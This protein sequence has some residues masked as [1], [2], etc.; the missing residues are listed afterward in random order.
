MAQKEK[1]K[2]KE[3]GG[4]R[5]SRSNAF[6]PQWSPVHHRIQTEELR[7]SEEETSERNQRAKEVGI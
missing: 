6:P 5:T 3:K 4:R 7:W 1:D 2:A